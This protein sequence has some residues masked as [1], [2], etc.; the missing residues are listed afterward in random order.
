MTNFIM[1]L[2]TAVIALFTFLAY[3]RSMSASRG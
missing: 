2:L 3:G 1:I